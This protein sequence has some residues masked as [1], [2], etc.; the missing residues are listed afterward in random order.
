MNSTEKQSLNLFIFIP[1]LI[2][3]TSCTAGSEQFSVTE[4]EGPADFWYGLWHGI[5]SIIA[6]I[7]HIFNDSVLVYETNNTGGW[8]DFGFLL[9]VIFVWG[10]GCHAKCKSTERR[11]RDA[12]WD[13][14]GNKIEIKVMRKLKNWADKEEAE[15]I[16]AVNKED[17]DE[18][19]E[20]VE[21]KL[22]RK[23]RDWAEKD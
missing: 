22:K 16:S 18:V 14:I 6:L 9:G 17:W 13:E 4:G 15:E 1:F 21:Q 3:L 10:G 2:I 7:I 20:K 23:L 8:Y 19:C 12:E 5:I 11:K